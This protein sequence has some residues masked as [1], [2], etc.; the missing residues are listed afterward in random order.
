MV[1]HGLL[2][3]GGG[4]GAQ[5]LGGLGGDAGGIGQGFEVEL[6]VDGHVV[7]GRDGAVDGGLEGVVAEL[8]GLIGRGLGALGGGRHGMHLLRGAGSAGP[9]LLHCGMWRLRTHPSREYCAVHNSLIRDRTTLPSA[10]ARALPP[11]S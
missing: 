4:L 5:G 8:G 10:W 7:E 6:G 11:R 1:F 3:V 9:N 2:A